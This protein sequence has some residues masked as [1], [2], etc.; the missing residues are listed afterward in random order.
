MNDHSHENPK[1]S[2]GVKVSSCMTL[3]N[4]KENNINQNREMLIKITELDGIMQ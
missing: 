1:S 4:V 2:V 3:Q